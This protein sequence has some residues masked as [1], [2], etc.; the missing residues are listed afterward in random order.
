MARDKLL[1]TA[2]SRLREEILELYQSLLFYQIKSVCFYHK[3]Q[4]GVFMRAFVDLDRWSDD[5]EEIRKAEEA[6]QR[7]IAQYDLESL[8][9]QV[10]ESR[11][12]MEEQFNQIL[13]ALK[14][15]SNAQ[16][17]I[18]Q[19]KQDSECIKLLCG[20]DPRSDID[21]IQSRKDDLI[22][23]SYKWILDIDEY[24][25]FIDW[26]DPDASLLWITGQAGT[27]KTMLLIGIIKELGLQGRLELDC[28]ELLF[29]FCQDGDKESNNSVAVLRGII[30]LLI[31][32]QPELMEYP[33]E[34]YRQSAGKHLTDGNVFITLRN[35][36]RAMLNDQRLGRVFLIIDALD[37]CS[38]A[39]RKEMTHFIYQEASAESRNRRVRWL[40]SSRPLPDIHRVIRP[41]SGV[42]ARI[43]VNEYILQEPIHAYIDRKISELKSRT[44]DE[45]R[46]DHISHQLKRKASNTFI[47]VSLVIRELKD[48]DIYRWTKVLEQ[49]PRDLGDLYKKLLGQLAKSDAKDECQRVLV[50]VM[51]ACRPL[52][53]AELEILSVLEPETA[54]DIV[55]Q[56]RSFLTVDGK[57]VYVLHES[58]QDYL[59]CHFRKLRDV[60]METLHGDI[61]LNS[62]QGLTALKRDIYNL[63]DPG[64]EIHHVCPPDPSPLYPFSYACQYWVFHLSHSNLDAVSPGM[65][66]AFLTVHLLHWLEA[67]SLLKRLP[68][69]IDMM[70]VLEELLQVGFKFVTSHTSN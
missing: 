32:Q 59:K 5:L 35:M 61:C 28:P 52:N 36:L 58:A 24:R 63:S 55:R 60:S 33:R 34:I 44:V 40:V 16:R 50:A 49:L 10:A 20:T 45:S 31:I 18:E 51:L 25:K 66:Q 56:C 70:R 54:L 6:L 69:T 15:T 11:S 43:D 7:D 42:V 12:Y 53:L 65:I 67:M 47:W 23:E 38:D 13:D 37:E 46:L 30:W 62:L 26:E 22:R 14:E 17:S 27:G 1:R 3:N 41:S 8:K 2:R 64:I 9:S 68:E 39:S 57:T 19:E 29:F 4:V 48:T 21:G